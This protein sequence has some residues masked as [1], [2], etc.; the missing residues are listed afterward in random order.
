LEFI[1]LQRTEP[2]L[3]SDLTLEYW[4]ECKTFFFKECPEF[5]YWALVGFSERSAILPFLKKKNLHRRHEQIMAE[6][7]TTYAKERLELKNII[8]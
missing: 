6:Y 2:L 1:N 7:K 3:A 5:V 8:E 4:Q